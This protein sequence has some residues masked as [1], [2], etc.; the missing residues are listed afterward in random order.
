MGEEGTLPGSM[1]YAMMTM[2]PK[3]GKSYNKKKSYKP[4]ALMNIYGKIL[5]NKIQQTTKRIYTTIKWD[6]FQEFKIELIFKIQ[7]I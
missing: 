2:M 4:I 5:S 3:P 7:L 1:L 6:L